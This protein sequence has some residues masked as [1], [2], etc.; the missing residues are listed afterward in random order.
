MTND[1]PRKLL[2]VALAL[3]PHAGLTPEG[4]ALLRAPLVA[5]LAPL[6]GP[7]AV[8]TT[9]DPS[10]ARVRAALAWLLAPAGDTIRERVQLRRLEAMA[11]EVAA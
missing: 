3:L 8:V 4:A 6:G 11:A 5:A 2:S 7:C 10:P 9:I 1:T